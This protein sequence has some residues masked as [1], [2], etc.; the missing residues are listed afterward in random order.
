M[1]TVG[2]TGTEA[3]I[4]ANLRAG[5]IV[6]PGEAIVGIDIILHF[7][8]EC[9]SRN[10][11]VRVAIAIEGVVV[12]LDVLSWAIINGVNS[13]TTVVI[14][15]VVIKEHVLAVIEGDCAIRASV[16]VDAIV[17]NLH[18]SVAGFQIGVWVC[19]TCPIDLETIIVIVVDLTVTENHVS[20]TGIKAM[21]TNTTAIIVHIHKGK[22]DAL[23]TK[24]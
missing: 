12:D 21:I 6:E 17:V 19:D 22:L 16:A 20:G 24:P 18:T 5:A 8:I 2:I 23:N 1:R 7:G 10:I 14:D 4:V 11:S 9:T 3:E 15:E 13:S